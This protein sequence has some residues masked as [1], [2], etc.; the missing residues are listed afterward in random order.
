MGE[1]SNVRVPEL[2]T[3]AGCK[4]TLAARM[5]SIV[6]AVL[7]HLHTIHAVL[8]CHPFCVTVL[9]LYLFNLHPNLAVICDWQGRRQDWSPETGKLGN[10]ELVVGGRLVVYYH[11][12]PTLTIP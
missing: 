2:K 10:A 4:R 9:Y 11:I 3:L 5:R 6:L 12:Y 7:H 1:Q 8:K